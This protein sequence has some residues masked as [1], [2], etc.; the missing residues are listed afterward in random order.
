MSHLLYFHIAAHSIAS[1]RKSAKADPAETETAPSE[2]PLPFPV[3]QSSVSQG[4]QLPSP[5]STAEPEETVVYT[6]EACS[7]ISQNGISFHFPA[8]ES[9]CRVELGFKVVND[10]YV[11]PKGYKDMPLVSSMLK[12][13]TSDVLP[14]P[15]TVR[16]EHCAIIE[17]NDSLVHMIAHG[18]PPY[19]FQPLL[20]GTFPLGERYGE[21]QVKRFSIFTTLAKKTGIDTVALSASFLP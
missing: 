5:S 13:T 18:P 4:S 1:R 7:H 3:Q 14:V 19:H 20:S 6:G 10:D 17:E 21:I 15:V 11:L 12:I 2:I 16:M 9:K 8:S